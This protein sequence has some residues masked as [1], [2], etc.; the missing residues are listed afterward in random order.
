MKLIFYTKKEKC[1]K[2]DKIIWNFVKTRNIY[3]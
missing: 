2:Y 1:E 3:Y